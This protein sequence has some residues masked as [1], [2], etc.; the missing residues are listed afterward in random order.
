MRVIQGGNTNEEIALSHFNVRKRAT[1]RQISEIVNLVD[2]SDYLVK[3]SK[4][5]VLV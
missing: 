4:L 2:D 1:T 3:S 5:D